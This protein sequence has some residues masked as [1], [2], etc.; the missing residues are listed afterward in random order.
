MKKYSQKPNYYTSLGIGLSD[1][2]ALN[3]GQMYEA[4]YNTFILDTQF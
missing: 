3:E 2:H 4:I 1:L